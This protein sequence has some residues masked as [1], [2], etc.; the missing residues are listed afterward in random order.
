MLRSLARPVTAA[1]AGVLAPGILALG[2]GAPAARAEPL[3][4][5]GTIRAA[6]WEAYRTRFMDPSGRIMDDANGNISHSEGQGYGMLLALAANDR[7]AFEQIW[8]FTRTELLI[9]DD[10]LAA[11]KWEP[12]ASPNVTDTNN[13]SD[14]DVLI[15][16]ALMLAAKAW[17]E[18]RYQNAAQSLVKA[19]GRVLLRESAGR[20]VMLPGA[21]GFTESDRPDGLL[22]VNPSY[23][24]FEAFE[25]FEA[26]APDHDW[27]RLRRDGIAIIEAGSQN[28]AGLPPDWL[29]IPPQGPMLPAQGFPPLFGYNSVR[30][31]LYLVRAGLTD[32][33]WLGSLRQRWSGG[34]IEVVDVTTGRAQEALTAR[35]YTM[36]APL[37]ACATAS[38]PLPEA[39][40]T[41]KLDLYYPS[42]LQ[43][44]AL[45]FVSEKF[46]RCL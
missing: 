2:L 36:W 16:Y 20:L 10:G 46:P 15:A 26:L 13:A 21:K 11:W 37:L 9:R 22:V 44:L 39:A 24:I 6:D 25:A 34:A 8:T 14:G 17:R 19:I 45:S 40:K 31:P 1:M 18:P 30:I 43:L 29:A 33:R 35:G 12:N 5:V 38:R 4:V 3:K 23:W 41:F 28:P 7:R 42:T 32:V 27:S